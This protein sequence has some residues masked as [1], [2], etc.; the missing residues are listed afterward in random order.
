M[1]L[2]IKIAHLILATA[3]CSA[4]E[5]DLGRYDKG[6]GR[7][8]PP[9]DAPQCPAPSKLTLSVDAYPDPTCNALQPFRG[10][11]QG[12]ERVVA[13]GGVGASQPALVGGSGRFC[14]EVMLL[15]SSTNT[16][17]FSPVDANGC[18]GQSLTRTIRHQGCGGP[19][20]G[21]SV[22]NIALGAAVASDS[23]PSA[24][25]GT[26]LT[27]GKTSTVVEY[28]GG[29]GWSDADFWVGI[30][31][32]RP[33]GVERVVVRWRDSAGGGCNYGTGYKIA[34]SAF[35]EPGP[36]DLNSGTWTQLK[37]IASGDGG[38]DEF[39][40]PDKPLA[41]H[42]ALLLNS[43]GC[44]SWSETFALAELEVWVA[45]PGSTPPPDRCP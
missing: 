17:V 39:T 35:S 38:T 37:D 4:T 20:A 29:W 33:A 41:Q 42:L 43:D 30:A 9:P 3:A 32:G 1:K 28:T 18:P 15:T 13:Q 11:A 10:T 19:D 25:Q 26:Y 27:D 6:P 16:I 12:A 14:V 23:E 7:D 40:F 45:D 21:A 24:G 31:L 8:A 34:S 44:T 22:V 2:L 36:M 5:P